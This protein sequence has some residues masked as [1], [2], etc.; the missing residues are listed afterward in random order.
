MTTPD[1]RQFLAGACA[2]FAGGCAG[3]SAP[4]ADA[5]AAAVP[6]F[7]LDEVTLDDLARGMAS[8]RWTAKKLTEAYLERIE[9]LDRRGPALRAVIEV[10][11]DALSIAEPLDRERA[12]GKVRGPLH[13]VPV[14]GEGQPR[15]RRPDAD[16]GGIAFAG[17]RAG[18]TRFVRGRNDCAS[19][20]RS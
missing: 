16:H 15:H 2:L 9:A 8:G 17:R 4:C 3:T 5:N 12:A 18:A 13:G 11:P 20:A 10:N 7:E 14:A 19:R 6:K 1:C